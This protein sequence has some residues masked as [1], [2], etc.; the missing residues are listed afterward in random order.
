MAVQIRELDEVTGE[1]VDA[2]YK[3]HKGLGPGLL[4]SVYEAVLEK[5]LRRR[6]LLVE[7]QKAVSFEYDGMRF[8]DGFRI[9][10]LVDTRVVVEIKSVEVLLPVHSK[11]VLTYLRLLY[12]PVG[13]LIN[14]GAPTLKE[15]VRRIVSD[16]S[17]SASSQLR[18]NRNKVS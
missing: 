4:E 9:D 3:L 6:G 12:L 18:V 15:G 5:D 10:L 14:F 11:Q 7:R 13:L 1:I 16:L 2:A 8:T 17:P